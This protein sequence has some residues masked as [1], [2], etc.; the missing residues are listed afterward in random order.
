MH[1][2]EEVSKIRSHLEILAYDIIINT[3][4]QHMFYS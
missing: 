3:A 1:I 2:M 4:D